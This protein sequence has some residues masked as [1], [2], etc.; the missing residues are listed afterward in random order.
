MSDRRGGRLAPGA[1]EAGFT[2]VELL[3]SIVILGVVIGSTGL[4]LVTLLRTER[5]ASERLSGSHSEQLITK[6][7]A[8]DVEEAITV[9]GG[10]LDAGCASHPSAAVGAPAANVV[11]FSSPDGYVSYRAVQEPVSMEWQLLRVA[12]AA[13][14]P[15]DVLVATHHLVDQDGAQL[16]P[17]ARPLDVSLR[18]DLRQPGDGLATSFTVSGS[19]ARLGT[20]VPPPT[21]PHAP[22]PATVTTTTTAPTT[23]TTTTT[24]TAPTT[25][26][27]TTTAPSGPAR[28]PARPQ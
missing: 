9:D 6:Y 21:V 28:N 20:L 2:L 18:L 16:L 23:T 26:T 19:R 24:T 1:G 11:R 17:S 12:C 3:V 5:T 27:T 22:P 4:A 14:A 7:F 8:A 25:T 10:D 15:A 13:G